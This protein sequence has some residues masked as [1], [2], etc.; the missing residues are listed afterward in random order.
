MRQAKPKISVIIPVY[1][2]EQYMF[3]C[4][5]ALQQQVQK[6]FEII[7]VDNNCTDASMVITKRFKNVKIIREQKQGLSYARNAGF[8]IATGDV[9]VRIDA[10]TIVPPSYIGSVQD[11]FMQSAHGAVTGY[12]VSRFELISNM[13]MLWAWFYFAYTEAYLGYSVLFGANNAFRRKYW[14]QIEPL[15]INDDA[16]VHEDQDISLALASIG[17][18]SKCNRSLTVS[19]DMASIQNYD[20]FRNYLERLRNIKHLDAI[21][22]RSKLPT[23]RKKSLFIKRAS[24]WALSAWTVYAYLTLLFLYSGLL[25]AKRAIAR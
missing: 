7:V 18:A 8:S 12:G 4:L 15:L 11:Y 19:V 1:N 16:K 3:D 17:V 5:T 9:L 23:R 13:S 20:I 2:D 6:P 10:D 14:K 22:H 21:H 24:L 25:S